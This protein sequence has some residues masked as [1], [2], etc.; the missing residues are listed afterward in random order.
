[1]CV[2]ERER[3]SVCEYVYI[4]VTSQLIVM[5]YYIASKD[6]I[7]MYIYVHQSVSA[8]YQKLSAS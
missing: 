4:E 5:S 7:C 6:R 8:T 2:C 3:E 1:M